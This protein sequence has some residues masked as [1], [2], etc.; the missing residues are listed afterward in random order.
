MTL[1]QDVLSY[2]R[3]LSGEVQLEP[4]GVEE[5]LNDIILTY[6]NLQPPN[7]EITLFKPLPRVMGNVASLT[8]VFSNL[9]G[10]AAK[11]V[12]PGV[13]PKIHVKAT[14]EA[15]FVRF[16]FEDNGIGI[17]RLAQKRIFQLFGRINSS[18]HYEGT[19]LGLAIVRKAVERMGGRVGVESELGKG[20][21]FW[22]SLRRANS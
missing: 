8:Q 21:R 20:S 7:V 5:L 16:W 1:I 11:F 10:N 4:V 14:L 12:A 13:R 15:K 3:I 9:L 22:V 2:S 6:P 18:E 19:G 17:E